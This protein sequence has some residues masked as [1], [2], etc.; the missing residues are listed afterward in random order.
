MAEIP[1][2][3]EVVVRN[4]AANLLHLAD[5]GSLIGR[6]DRADISR[7]A[8]CVDHTHGCGQTHLEARALRDIALAARLAEILIGGSCLA[9]VAELAEA[10]L[11]RL[12]AFGKTQERETAGLADRAARIRPQ[13][14]TGPQQRILE[15]HPKPARTWLSVGNPLE[16]FAERPADGA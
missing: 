7:R 6:F 5:G 12:H 15:A 1:L 4:G 10:D 8:E 9:R 14:R 16:A 13:K 11:G 3:A 2:D